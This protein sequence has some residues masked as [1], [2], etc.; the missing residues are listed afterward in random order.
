[1][2][3]L[4]ITLQVAIVV[5]ILIKYD[6]DMYVLYYS[7]EVLLYLGKLDHVSILKRYGGLTVDYGDLTVNLF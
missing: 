5:E 6:S 3:G 1:M 4:T 2:Q 7:A